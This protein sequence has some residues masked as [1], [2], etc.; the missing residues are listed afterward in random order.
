MDTLPP[1]FPRERPGREAD[2][3]S[4]PIVAISR[5]VGPKLAPSFVFMPWRLIKHRDN[6]TISSERVGGNYKQDSSS[7]PLDKLR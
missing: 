2:Q 1:Y 4:P 5:D 7:K 6:F 3:S